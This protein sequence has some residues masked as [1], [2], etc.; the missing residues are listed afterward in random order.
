M[1]IT[2]KINP[3]SKQ[4]KA[5]LEYLKVLP[6]VQIEEKDK[7][8]YTPEFTDKIKKGEADIKKGKTTRINPDNVWENIL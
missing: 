4:A 1:E 8:G 3:R 7:S 2:I 5:F 6:F